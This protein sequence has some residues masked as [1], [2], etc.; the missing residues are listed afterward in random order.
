MGLYFGY[1]T[2]RN[3][4]LSMDALAGVNHAYYMVSQVETQKQITEVIMCTMILLLV[5]YLSLF[6]GHLI[7][8][9]EQ[10]LKKDKSDRFCTYCRGK[11][12]TVDQCFKLNGYPDWFK[13]RTKGSSRTASVA[14]LIAPTGQDPVQ[15]DSLDSGGSFSVQESKMDS[16]LVSVKK[17]SRLLRALL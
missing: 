10:N 3:Q 1:E 15:H 17:S 8:V 5:P 4:I 2:A 11:G 7:L 14:Q 16:N 9:G 12:Y 6:S 13:E